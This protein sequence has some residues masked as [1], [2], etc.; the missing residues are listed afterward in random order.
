MKV[1]DSNLNW[2]NLSGEFVQFFGLRVRTLPAGYACGTPKSFR[3]KILDHF[4][5]TSRIL[6]VQTFL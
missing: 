2:A 6:Q 1:R 4:I 5:H 3:S